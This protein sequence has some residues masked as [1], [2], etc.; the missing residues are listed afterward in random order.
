MGVPPTGNVIGKLV[1]IW[2]VGFKSLML[3]NN[4]FPIPPKTLFT[5]VIIRVAESPTDRYFTPGPS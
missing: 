5:S 1:L 2:A 4:D 3:I